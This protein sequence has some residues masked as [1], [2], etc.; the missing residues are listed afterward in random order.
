MPRSRA[1]LSFDVL[2]GEKPRLTPPG[3]LGGLERRIFVS[4][5]NS[6]PA[7]HFVAE[8]IDLLRAYVNAIAMERRSADELAGGTRDP[9]YV[10]MHAGAVRRMRTLATKLRIGPQSRNRNNNLRR[11]ATTRAEVS[12]YDLMDDDISPPTFK[13]FRE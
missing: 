6:V 3:D 5:V 8:D 12:A 9:F 4:I 7:A 1:D 11:H 13:G 10:S 2:R